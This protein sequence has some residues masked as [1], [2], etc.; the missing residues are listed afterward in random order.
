MG[1]PTKPRNNG[2]ELAIA[3]TAR[4]GKSARISYTKVNG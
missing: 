1:S 2:V 3:K 4:H